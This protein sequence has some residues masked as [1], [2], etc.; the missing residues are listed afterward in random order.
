MEMTGPMAM[1]G[2]PIWL[3]GGCEFWFFLKSLFCMR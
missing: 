3:V 1:A 2:P